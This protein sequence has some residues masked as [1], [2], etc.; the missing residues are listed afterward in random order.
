[1]G[2]VQDIR[3][4]PESG[5]MQLVAEYRDRLLRDA[6]AMCGDA[7][8]AEDFVFK[9]F[10]KAIRNIGT[11]REE[12]SLYDWMRTIL[13]NEIR[14]ARRSKVVQNTVVTAIDDDT[15]ASGAVS[16]VDDAV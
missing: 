13:Q 4:D 7:A 9:T 16:M 10:D 8:E 14:S 11:V 15:V 12:G 6:V 5:A 3:S 2:V 1:M